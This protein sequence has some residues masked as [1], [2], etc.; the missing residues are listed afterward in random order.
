MAEI[1]AAAAIFIIL[2]L[3]IAVLVIVAHWFVYT[4]A[5]KP[6]WAALIPI[7]NTIVLL[8]IVGKPWLHLTYQQFFPFGIWLSLSILRTSGFAVSG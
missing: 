5:G 1:F 6:G 4:K 2:G 3:S 8:E 7:Y